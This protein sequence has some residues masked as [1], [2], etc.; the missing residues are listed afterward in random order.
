MNTETDGRP[1]IEVYASNAALRRRRVRAVVAAAALGRRIQTLISYALFPRGCADLFWEN[2]PGHAGEGPKCRRVETAVAGRLRPHLTPSDV[3]ERLQA[4]T[5][6]HEVRALV[7]VECGAGVWAGSGNY[8][9]RVAV[10]D[11]V[12]T[13]RE[14]GRPFPYGT[15]ICES[16]ESRCEQEPVAEAA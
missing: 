16:C 12:E 3:A 1:T 4:V 5:P 15:H 8:V 14:C 9:N 11:D 2:R 13:N 6:G 10:C 7:C